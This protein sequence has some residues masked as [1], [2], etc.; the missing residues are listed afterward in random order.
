MTKTYFISQRFF[1]IISSFFFVFEGNT[2]TE[3]GLQD[4]INY[5]I[6]NNIS[7]KEAELQKRLATITVEQSKFSFWP[8]LSF[9]GSS[10]YRFGLSENP[11][12]GTMQSNNFFSTGFSLSGGLI[13]FNWFE[14]H[15]QL[16]AALIS[17]EADDLGIQKMRND[18]TMIV[19]ASYLQALLA[20][21]MIK[22]AIVQVQQSVT[23]TE[24]TE[25]KAKLGLMTQLDIAQVRQQQLS[26]SIFLL[27]AEAAYEKALLQLKAVLALDAGFILKIQEFPLTDE[28]SVSILEVTPEKLFASAVHKQ[29]QVKGIQLQTEAKKERIKA[30]KT[31]RYP[32]FSLYGS[33]GSSFID[34]PSAQAYT[35]FPSQPTGAK[36]KVNG[37]SYDVMAPTYSVSSYG[38]TP[39]FQQVHKNLGQ[40]FGISISIPILNGKTSFV[41]QKREEINLMQLKLQAQKIYQELKT[42]FFSAYFDTELALKK[43][44]LS[45]KA[46]NQ[47]LKIYEATQK[48]YSLNLLST[49]DLL[50]ANNNFVKAKVELF[51]AEYELALRIKALEFYLN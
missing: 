38:V 4:C 3:W 48:I 51:V 13:L 40:N 49:Q 20:N 16:K 30:L 25:K 10:G 43:R 36:V 26:D 31:A 6:K 39:F 44:E 46:L 29:P 47:A 23:Q 35:Y 32:I 34:I 2:Q 22:V 18:I 45:K 24:A 9:S 37:V 11:T 14:K 12:T 21:E 15:H 33:T 42:I 27:N 17:L 7:V 19:S 50:I 8:S 5:A 28:A 41:N 1:L